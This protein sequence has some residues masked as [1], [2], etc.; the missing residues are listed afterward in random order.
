MSVGIGL[1][2]QWLLGGVPVSDKVIVV[3]ERDAAEVLVGR[4]W[5]RAADESADSVRALRDYSPVIRAALDRDPDELVEQ[6]ARAIRS[7]SQVERDASF[8]GVI[9]AEC[10]WSLSASG[11]NYAEHAAR[12]AIAAL[13]GKGKD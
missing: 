12:A 9:C 8:G 10:G 3:M 5:D 1:T 2:G 7:H 13:T 6:V 4:G 11:M